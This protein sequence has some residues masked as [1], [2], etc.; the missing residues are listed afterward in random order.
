MSDGDRSNIP[1]RITAPAEILKPEVVKLLL[2]VPERWQVYRPDELSEPQSQALFL[3]TAAG[4]VE[5]RERMRLMMLNHPLIVE[6]TICATGEYGAVEAMM[7]LAAQMWKD[8]QDAFRL[9]QEG[10][11]H[12]I[13]PF[14]CER[15]EPAEWRLTDQGI[16]ARK[17]VKS[18][19]KN[20]ALDFVLKRGF[21]DGL[22]YQKPDGSLSI[23]RPV[24]GKGALVRIKKLKGEPPNA[25]EIANWGEGAEA[26]ANAFAGLNH[27]S[28]PSP[29]AMGAVFP[30]VRLGLAITLSI[31][32]ESLA[33]LLAWQWGDGN[34][35]L[36][37]I[38]NCWWLLV[39]VS[40]A[41][42]FVF[43]LILG[44]EGWSQVKKKWHS[45]RGEA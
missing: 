31:V 12:N 42:P 18:G 26:F 40:A 45:W 15:L 19:N 8:W 39:F 33:V 14:H 11:T 43:R 35:L 10:H 41:A 20:I 9:W 16:I 3:L 4:M 1:G 5:R 44:R 36:Q 28:Q 24:R 22:P 27:I 32:L 34:N 37:K 29:G 7:P 38:G 21:F 2:R 23:R 25:L 6:A 17:D 13:P 30:R